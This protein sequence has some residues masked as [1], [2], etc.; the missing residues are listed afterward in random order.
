MI[1]HLPDRTLSYSPN[2]KRR[3]AERKGR[4]EREEVKRG[5]YEG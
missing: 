1:A 5:R 2:T 3:K 4:Q